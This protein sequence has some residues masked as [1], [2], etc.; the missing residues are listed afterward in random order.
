MGGWH[1]ERI[2]VHMCGFD[3]I[4]RSN[5]FQQEPIG[6]AEVR[7]RVRKLKNGKAAVR[8]RSLEK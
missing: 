5:Y 6:K 4:W 1:K 7:V 8:M 3:G 2:A